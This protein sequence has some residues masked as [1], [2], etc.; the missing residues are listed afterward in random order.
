M[1]V[2]GAMLKINGIVNKESLLTALKDS[3]P[4]RYHNLLPLNEKAIEL[5]MGLVEK[6]KSVS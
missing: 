6:A 4:E 1:I 2:L 5:G 3:L